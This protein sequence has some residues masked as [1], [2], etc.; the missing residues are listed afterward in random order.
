MTL[1]V[2]DPV[3]VAKDGT[4]VTT[5]KLEE[6]NG[7]DGTVN[8]AVDVQNDSGAE[9]NVTVRYMKKEVQKQRRNK[10]EP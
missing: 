1:I 10:P 8:V 7:S 9:A 5:P 4:F 6:S 2:T 3:H